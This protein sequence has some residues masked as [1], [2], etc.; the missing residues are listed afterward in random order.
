VAHNWATQDPRSLASSPGGGGPGPPG[1]GQHPHRHVD[2][3]FSFLAVRYTRV[4]QRCEAERRVR[5]CV[6]L[7]YA[8]YTGGGGDS[9]LECSEG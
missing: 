4:S 6:L 9:M 1:G 8:L 2:A 3:G 5:C 7:C